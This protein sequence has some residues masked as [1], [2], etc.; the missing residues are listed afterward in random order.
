[1]YQSYH[2]GYG[3][4]FFSVLKSAGVALAISF[5]ASVIFAVVLRFS[6]GSGQMIYVIN[7]I[8]KVVSIVVG[9]LLF[10][11]GEKGWLKGGGVGLLFTALSYLAFSAFGG[12]FSLTWL[13]FVELFFALLSGAIG[14]MIAVNI[15]GSVTSS[16]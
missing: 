14:G 2:K 7:Q 11:R 6:A 10:L 16:G 8:T 5:F 1:M 3:E 12:D 9:S 4:D 15:K 13:I